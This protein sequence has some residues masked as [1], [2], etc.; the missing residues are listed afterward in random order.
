MKRTYID[1]S[2]L[3]TAARG[4]ASN[5]ARAMEVLDDPDREFVTSNFV[6]L[7]VVPKAAYMRSNDELEFYKTFF[8]GCVKRVEGTRDI[9]RRGYREAVAHGLS[10]MDALHV[11]SAADGKAVELVTLEQP[12]KPMH[13]TTLIRIACLDS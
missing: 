13:R 11:V 3:I 2:V 8:E 10:A 6:E 7:E 12:T 4:T 5:C 1:S 9:L